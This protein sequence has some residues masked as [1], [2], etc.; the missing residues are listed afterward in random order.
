MSNTQ[1]ITHDPVRHSVV[2]PGTY[3][4]SRAIFCQLVALS[5]AAAACDA[6]ETQPETQP[7]PELPVRH[8][9]VVETNDLT[10]TRHSSGV[11][12]NGMSLNGMSLNGMSLNGVSLQGMSLNGMSL[13]GMSL[14]GMS[15]NGMSLNGMSLNGMSL[16]GLGL[17]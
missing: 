14:N 10:V 9:T 6:G 17:N 8:S 2:I 4:S 13:N 15:L 5:C 12:L 3:P 7:Q 16:N 11:T 1:K